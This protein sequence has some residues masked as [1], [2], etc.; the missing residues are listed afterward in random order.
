MHNNKKSKAYLDF[1]EKICIYYLTKATFPDFVNSTNK[2][3]EGI[4]QRFIEP[5]GN[6]ESLIQAIWSP[7]VC[8]LSKKQNNRDLY[9]MSY[10]A[11]G[12]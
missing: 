4:L 3:L 7:S 6:H 2:P 1:D 9:D 12:N 10:D 8:I 11:Y 5:L